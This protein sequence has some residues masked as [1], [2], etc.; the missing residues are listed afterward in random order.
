MLGMSE[1]QCAEGRK[2]DPY[3]WFVVDDLPK[4]PCQTQSQHGRF[5][6]TEKDI[7]EC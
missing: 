6:D 2:G 5:M 7:S 4:N 1:L 3:R